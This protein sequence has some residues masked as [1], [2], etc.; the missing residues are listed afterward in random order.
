MDVNQPTVS[1]AQPALATSTEKTPLQGIGGWLILPVLGLFYML[2]QTMMMVLFDINQVK[3]VWPLVTNIDS[4]F[5]ISGFSVSFYGLQISHCLLVALLVWTFVSAL[6][7]QKKAKRLFIIT[8]IFYVLMVVFSRFIFPNI[9]GIEIKYSYMTTLV[10][11]VFYCFIWIPYFFLSV[12]V[13]QT[14]IR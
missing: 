13:K 3:T 2:Y 11:S 8:M 5:Y 12:R 4:D 1:T 10:N 7:W 14:F 9:F 6:K